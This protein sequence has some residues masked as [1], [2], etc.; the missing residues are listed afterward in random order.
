MYY[1]QPCLLAKSPIAKQNC[2]HRANV[3]CDGSSS[4]SR[5]EISRS[6]MKASHQIRAVFALLWHNACGSASVP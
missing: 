5:L 4:R 1:F 3:I 6:F 2:S